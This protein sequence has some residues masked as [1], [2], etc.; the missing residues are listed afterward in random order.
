MKNTITFRGI[1]VKNIGTIARCNAPAI[2]VH[3]A[4]A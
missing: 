2:K 3:A 1:C 4:A